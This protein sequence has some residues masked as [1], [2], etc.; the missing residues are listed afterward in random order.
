MDQLIK[1]KD[2]QDLL[3]NKHKYF[4]NEVKGH[5]GI[6]EYGERQGE[7]NEI[8]KFYKHPGL[9]EGVFMRETYQSDSYGDNLAITEIGFVEGKAKTITVFE[10]IV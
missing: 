9:P 1:L 6:G 5:I 10:P 7:Y 2:L 4:T 8:Y 3:G